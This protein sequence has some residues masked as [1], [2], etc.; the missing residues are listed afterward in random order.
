MLYRGHSNPI[1]IVCFF[2]TLQ[3]RGDL[4][5]GHEILQLDG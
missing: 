2:Y 3:G 1:Y 5:N 4:D